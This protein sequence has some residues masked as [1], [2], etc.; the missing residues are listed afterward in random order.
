MIEK[1]I[2][3]HIASQFP[4]FYKSDGPN[5][6]AFVEAY[7]EWMESSNNPLYH[8]RRL[9]E[10]ADI[11]ETADQFIKYFKNTYINSLP[12]SIAGDKRLL[13]KHILD[14]YRAKG[15][16]RSIK[17]LFRLLFDESIDLYIPGDYLLRP[18]DGEWKKQYYIETTSSPYL[19]DTIGKLIRNSSGSAT[20]IVES[21]TTKK[22]NKKTI[23]VL[24]LSSLSGEFKYGE[25]LLCSE[26][27]ELTLD[28]APV[29]VG[30]MTA[31]AMENGGFDFNVGDFLS[32]SGSGFDGRARV[33]ATR[34][35][36]G[37][38]NFNLLNGGSGYSLNPNI[39]VST[40][41]ELTITNLS[42]GQFSNSDVILD[43]GSG[44]NATVTFAN[45]SFIQVINFSPNVEF[46]VGHTITNGNTTAQIVD[47]IGG[48]GS[49]ASFTVG[50][51]TD[52]EIFT[53]NTDVI[54]NYYNTSLDDNAYGYKVNITGTSGAGFTVGNTATS[55]ANVVL[56]EAFGISA[57]Q[58]SEGES[59]S[60]TSLGISGLTTYRVDGNFIWCI[61]SESNLSNA[62]LAPG[63]ILLS[64][65]TV[66]SI[67]LYNNLPKYTV[68]ATGTISTV[69]STAVVV[70]S[71]VGEY[72]P[73]KT[74]TDLN[75]GTTATIVSQDRL[76]NWIFPSRPST[77]TNLDTLIG[78]TLDAVTIEV[79]KIAYLG[80]ISPGNG[81][82]TAPY[83]EVIEP[84]ISALN[85]F[86]GEGS[87]KGRNAVINSQVSN[88]SGIATAVD[89][90]DSGFGYV[91]NETVYLSKE[92]SEVI[93]KGSAI[94]DRN[95]EEYGKWVNRKGFLSDIN[96]LQDSRYYQ[97]FSYEIVAMRMLETYESLVRDLVH[98]SGLALFGKYQL[99][100]DLVNQ[101][102]SISYSS[103]TQT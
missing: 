9:L 54:N 42:N 15:T 17:L 34:D 32:V 22:I 91:S 50:A 75:T 68:T 25:R 43:T 10:Y 80:R 87:Y 82:L 20:A 14:L 11:D 16:D 3:P 92:N 8:S 37:K 58:V 28:N 4:S 45:S 96:K 62:N 59:L 79:G 61:G 102:S 97:L 65:T 31:I 51:L 73:S 81:Y 67:Q 12:E 69:N 99:R 39:T 66:S 21:Y 95:G 100:S 13:M 18:S 94:V 88:K 30:S 90:I 41:K 60:N 85:E 63:V 53:I 83:I 86:D 24:Y 29:I 36:T 19:N 55:T 72:V 40:T 26:V 47:S 64:N 57:N 70:T 35:E 89:V 7:Y 52:P 71:P 48:T 77:I 38:V 49:G 98:P 23:N 2:S 33:A 5:F 56:L 44:A 103:I 93:I 1:L 27:S 78:D 46:Q 6:I 76:S 84:G 101:Q 74:I